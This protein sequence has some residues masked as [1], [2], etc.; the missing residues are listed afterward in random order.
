MYEDKMKS[1][2]IIEVESQEALSS[3]QK[4]N[5][6]NVISYSNIIPKNVQEIIDEVIND[7]NF[8]R[9]HD[10]MEHMN[11]KWSGEVPSI[12]RLKTKA[13][14][15][16]QDAYIKYLINHTNEQYTIRTG[17]LEAYYENIDGEDYFELKFV[18]TSVNNY[19]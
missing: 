6:V 5:G 14:N 3:L 17:G 10:V 7:F 19:Y 8:N 11:W 9:V 12:E 18:L 2:L 15:L 4:I 1:Q 16:L 13:S